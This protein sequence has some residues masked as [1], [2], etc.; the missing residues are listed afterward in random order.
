MEKLNEFSKHIY[1]LLE[2]LDAAKRNQYD[3]GECETFQIYYAYVGRH[4]QPDVY[5]KRPCLI[6]N[7]FGNKVAVLKLTSKYYA[8]DLKYQ[9]KELDNLSLD[10]DTYI[11][12]DEKPYTI[13]KD[14]ITMYVG[15][16]DRIDADALKNQLFAK[17]VRSKI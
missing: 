14:W 6:L 12:L 8:S 15:D 7:D 4:D 16:L 1:T 9:I 11:R 5:D 3:C 2:V 10:G 13:N 17:K